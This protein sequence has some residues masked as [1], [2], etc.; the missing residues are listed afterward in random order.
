MLLR[1]KSLFAG[2]TITGA[3]V[4]SVALTSTTPS[5]WVHTP[6][7]TIMST[8]IFGGMFGFV[9]K[10]LVVQSWH[11]RASVGILGISAVS[12]VARYYELIPN[13]HSEPLISIN[14]STSEKI[15]KITDDSSE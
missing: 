13:M 12:T 2:S 5:D 15:T 6:L 4:G 3:C 1:C 10:Q 14:F 9:M 8:A 11:G 7:A